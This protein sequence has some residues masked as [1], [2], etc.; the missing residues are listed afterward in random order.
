MRCGARHMSITIEQLNAADAADF[1]RLLDGLY[2]HTDWV[3]Q[4]AA[5]QRPFASAAALLQA[6][7]GCV[8][9]ASETEQLAL[10]R[11]HPELGMARAAPSAV[12]AAQ[13]G[14]SAPAEA[15]LTAAYA[16]EQRLAGLRAA[17]LPDAVQDGLRRDNAA[18]RERFGFPFVLA[19]RGADG[20]G[21]APQAILATL[22]RRLHHTPAQERDEALRQINR[23]AELRLQGMLGADAALGRSVL[24]RCDELAAHSGAEN[25]PSGP[26]PSAAHLACAEDLLGW[27]REAG[28]EAQIDAC[29]NVIGR[30]PCEAKGARTLLA[31]SHYDTAP[32]AGK[33]AGRAGVLLALAVAAELRL[34]ALRLPFHFDV[35]AFAQAHR[36]HLGTPFMQAAPLGFVEFDIEPGASLFA[37]QLPL[38]IATEMPA[39]HASAE[40]GQAACDADLQARCAR[41]M[42]A[43]GLPVRYLASSGHRAAEEISGGTPAAALLIRRGNGEAGY[44]PLASV[45]AEDLEWAAQ[46]FERVVLD[47]AETEWASLQT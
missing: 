13:A 27:M 12:S 4:R 20:S 37:E 39:A 19:V 10:I 17:A 1:V 15:P 33:Y 35:V 3:T 43:L 44:G 22:R 29:G 42:A 45:T 24:R 14:G 8:A 6:V 23:I 9:R 30:Y 36:A 46:V 38:G 5:A 31:G 25:A 40:P 26:Y 34:R 41:A 47:L 11:A 7:W 32:D 2:E 16:H 28:L 18:Y 21:M